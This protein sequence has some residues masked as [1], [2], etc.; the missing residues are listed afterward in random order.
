MCVYALA[1]S[2]HLFYTPFSTYSAFLPLMKNI[3][4]F[5]SVLKR[6]MP[7]KLQLPSIYQRLLSAMSTLFCCVRYS[8]KGGSVNPKVSHAYTEYCHQVSEH[9]QAV[10]QK[11]L[12]NFAI[13]PNIPTHA[14]G[15]ANVLDSS[16]YH[17]VGG[18]EIIR[19]H[20]VISEHRIVTVT[21]YIHVLHVTVSAKT[22]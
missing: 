22:S 9:K 18:N 20:P 21:T 16:V 10:R 8:T 14:S 13:T 5:R 12:W 17:W 7:K 15:A 1:L 11:R 6:T 2:I 4:V 19:N 3:R